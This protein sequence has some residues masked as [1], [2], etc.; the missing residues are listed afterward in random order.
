VV[1]DDL[2]AVGRFFEDQ[3]EDASCIA[4]IFFAS[5][6]VIFAYADGEVFVE[7]VDLKLGEGE[8][9]HGGAVGVVA[10]VLVY[11]AS[12]AAGDLVGDEEGVGRV[13]VAADEGGDVAAVP[14]CLLREKDLDDVEFLAGGGVER[15][16]CLR[17]EGDG[18][19]EGEEDGSKAKGGTQCHGEPRRGS[20]LDWRDFLVLFHRRSVGRVGLIVDHSSD[21]FGLMNLS[22]VTVR[23]PF[24]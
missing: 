7:G 4:A 22:T 19:E 23:A 14:G 16:R 2:P 24:R 9:A 12:I 15:L 21:R 8:G 10:F 6:E 17:G 18:Y 1:D 3:G 20:S 11:E 5:F 13:F